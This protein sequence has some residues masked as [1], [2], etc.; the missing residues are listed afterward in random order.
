M[1][2]ENVLL[3]KCCSF[4]VFRLGNT[5]NSVDAA[6]KMLSLSD[7]ML[8]FCLTMGNLNRALYFICDNVLWAKSIGLI[9]NINKDRWNQNANKYFFFS[10][11]LNLMRDVYV[12]CQLMAQLSRDRKFQQ[13]VNQHLNESPDV[14]TVLIPQLDAFLFL[15]LE[16]LRSHPA[17]ALDTLKNVCDLF[18]PLDKLG[19]YQ[20]STGVVG[21]CGL[22]SSLLGI[23]SVLKP[24]LK[25]Q[26]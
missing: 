5:V 23:L 15:L 25:I 1:E 26:P 14:A 8:R 13:K 17:V 10:L 18:I 19:L 21:L 6:K 12:I 7:H 4:S 9:Q 11:V 16:S 24:S 3:I 20:T 2:Q 22:V